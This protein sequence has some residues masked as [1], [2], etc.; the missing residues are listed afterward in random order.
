M[1]VHFAPR[2]AQ[3]KLS[4]HFPCEK[5]HFLNPNKISTETALA[6]RKMDEVLGAIAGRRR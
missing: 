6:Q 5:Y 1:A 2:A 3:G 4:L